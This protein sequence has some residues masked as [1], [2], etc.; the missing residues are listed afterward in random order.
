M[1]LFRQWKVWYNH[2]R[3]VVQRH[4][5]HENL[6]TNWT[7]CLKKKKKKCIK[8]NN[9]QFIQVFVLRSSKDICVTLKE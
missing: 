4:L 6:S 9:Q 5:R 1:F 7:D 2:T 3:Y 8:E